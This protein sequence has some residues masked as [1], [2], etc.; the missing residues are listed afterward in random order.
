V[1][2]VK[3]DEKSNQNQRGTDEYEMGSVEKL[4]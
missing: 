1:Q 4:L 3:L 2:E